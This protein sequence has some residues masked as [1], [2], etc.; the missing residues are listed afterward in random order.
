LTW[1]NE[2]FNTLI[3]NAVGAMAI[4]T[5]HV[6]TSALLF[7]GLDRANLFRVPAASEIAGLDI[8]KH[9]EPAYGFGIVQYAP[10]FTSPTVCLK[11]TFLLFLSIKKMMKKVVFSRKIVC[12]FMFVFFL[13]VFLVL[14]F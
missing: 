4:V 5:W 14:G 3:W 13:L 10:I 1:S 9:N 6:T 2:S 12:I 7:V 8:I 11:M